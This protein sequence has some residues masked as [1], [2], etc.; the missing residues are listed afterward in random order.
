M[1]VANRRSMSMRA[2]LVV[3]SFRVVTGVIPG[4]GYSGRNDRP[5]GHQRPSERLV[6]RLYRPDGRPTRS[7]V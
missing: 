3:M 2:R 6:K 7:F 5:P 1:G 4:S